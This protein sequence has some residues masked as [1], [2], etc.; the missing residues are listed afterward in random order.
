MN[1]DKLKII[2][3]NKEVDNAEISTKFSLMEAKKDFISIDDFI[4]FF[5][6]SNIMKELFEENLEES[7]LKKSLLYKEYKNIGLNPTNN[8]YFKVIYRMHK[9][10]GLEIC[11]HIYLYRI[12][13]NLEINKEP[14]LPW[15]YIGNKKYIA[16]T[17]WGKDEEIIND[18][19]KLTLVDFIAKY[20]GI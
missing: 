20:K 3:R 11:E 8:N 13:S 6:I 16:D 18:I 14:L 2:V 15:Y 7:E 12:V 1:I 4:S 19:N 5:G 17:W 9:D 10:I